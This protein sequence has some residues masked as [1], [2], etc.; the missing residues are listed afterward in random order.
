MGVPRVTLPEPQQIE[1]VLSVA[2]I[3]LVPSR[4]LGRDSFDLRISST[5]GHVTRFKLCP[6]DPLAR[7]MLAGIRVAL[8]ST[9]K[10]ER[11]W[12]ETKSDR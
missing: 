8:D 9:A 1:L 4:H 5:K 6:E 3:A 7:A 11:D 2:N 12:F 10:A